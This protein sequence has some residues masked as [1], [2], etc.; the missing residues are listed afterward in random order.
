[1]SAIKFF[2]PR[3]ANDVSKDTIKRTFQKLLI[4]NIS[5]IDIHRKKNKKGEYLFAFIELILYN[6]SCANAIRRQLEEKG[7]TKIIYDEPEFWEIKSYVPVEERI[8]KKKNKIHDICQELMKPPPVIPFSI[9]PFYYWDLPS[10][11][12]CI[13]TES[14]FDIE[15]GEI[16]ENEFDELEKEIYAEY[17]SCY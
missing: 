2:I 4:G 8:G 12:N 15:D 6:T 14:V 11:K 1:M 13:I 17:T 16:L 9:I 7:Y 3:I 10:V 5:D